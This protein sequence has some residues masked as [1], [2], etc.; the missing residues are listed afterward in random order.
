MKS[1]DNKEF[2]YFQFKVF[3]FPQDFFEK[4]EIE[5]LHLHWLCLGSSWF[6]NDIERAFGPSGLI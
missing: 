5:Y 3:F 6:E 4:N 2:E 1:V